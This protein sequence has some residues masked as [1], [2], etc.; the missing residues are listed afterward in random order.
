MIAS[1]DTLM[2][3]TIPSLVICSIIGTLP[4]FPTRRSS[5]LGTAASAPDRH[6]VRERRSQRPGLPLPSTHRPRD[7]TDEPARSEEH[8]SEL[9]HLVI[10]YSV[11]CLKKTSVI[12]CTV[13]NRYGIEDVE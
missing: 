9:S 6:G 13:G 2:T 1:C 5:D 11:F 10:S 8:K 7:G 4:S 12:I 3:L